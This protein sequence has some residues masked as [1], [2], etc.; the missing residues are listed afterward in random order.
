MNVPLIQ[1]GSLW[2]DASDE[3]SA[4]P[5]YACYA[6]DI[7]C[8]ITSVSGDETFKGRTLEPGVS[9]VI[10]MDYDGTIKPDWKF[11]PSTGV[12][13]NCAMFV[14]FVKHIPYR[15]GKP[16]RTWLYCREVVPT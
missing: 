3:D 7:C 12:Y 15:D 14:T 9:Y 5:V 16:P 8:D 1:R 11:I 13:A 6:A 2:S 10:E 4:D